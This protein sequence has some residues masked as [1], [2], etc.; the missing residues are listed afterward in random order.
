[1]KN[2]PA[3]LH[4]YIP[5]KGKP[6]EKRWIEIRS[7]E[8]ETENLRVLTRGNHAEGVACI[9]FQHPRRDAGID[10]TQV[11]LDLFKIKS[12]PVE[13]NKCFF[14]ELARKMSVAPLEM[15]KY[16]INSSGKESNRSG[17]KY[18][19]VQTRHC[20]WQGFLVERLGELKFI[21]RAMVSL[22][23]W[24]IGT[25]L[26]FLHKQDNPIRM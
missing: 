16:Y 24:S 6:N 15:L 9:T 20:K 22:S 4:V 25:R 17:D 1:M 19:G 11:P 10:G 21:N 2:G 26:D 7:S 3:C 5:R 18:G 8:R 14:Y 12:N 23:S 13:K